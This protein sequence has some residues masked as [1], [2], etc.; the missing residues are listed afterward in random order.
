LGGASKLIKPHARASG[1]FEP[2]TKAAARPLFAPLQSVP[3]QLLS[4]EACEITQQIPFQVPD[5][6]R[7]GDVHLP[8]AKRGHSDKSAHQHLYQELAAKHSAD[9]STLTPPDDIITGCCLD[10]FH[11]NISGLSKSPIKSPISAHA[12][13][14]S[15]RRTEVPNTPAQHS[16]Q[17]NIP[18]SLIDPGGAMTEDD[19]VPGDGALHVE[20]TP[21]AKVTFGTVLCN[22]CHKQRLLARTGSTKTTC[23]KCQ[24][25]SLVG[26]PKKLEIPETP[27]SSAVTQNSQH[28]QQTSAVTRNSHLEQISAVVAQKSQSGQTTASM[29]QRSQPEKVATATTD[30]KSSKVTVPWFESGVVAAKPKIKKKIGQLAHVETLYDQDMI[31]EC[32]ASPCLE[33]TM[34][35]SKDADAISQ[36]YTTSLGTTR[37]SVSTKESQICVNES[38]QRECQNVGASDRLK[39]LSYGKRTKEEIHSGPPSTSSRSRGEASTPVSVSE[40]S[41]DNTVDSE[42]E[43]SL[44]KTS[45]LKEAQKFAGSATES[46]HESLTQG[47]RYGVRELARIALVSANGNHMTTSQVLIWIAQ[48]FPYLR[49]GEGGWERSVQACLSRFDEFDGRTIP[50]DRRNKKLYGFSGVE[51]R[52][53]YEKEYSEFLAASDSPTGTEGKAS[54]NNEINNEKPVNGMTAEE[55][56]PSQSFLIKKQARSNDQM[57]RHGSQIQGSP[58]NIEANSR[59]SLLSPKLRANH[60]ATEPPIS[61]ALPEEASNTIPL[62]PSARS[63]TSQPSGLSQPHQNI[64]RIITFQAAF[65]DSTPSI[66]TMTEAEKAQRIA[67]IKARPSRK[68]YFG[69]DYRLAHKRRYGLKDIHDEREG[70]WKRPRATMNELQPNMTGNVDPDTGEALTL[71]SLFGLPNNAIPMNDGHKELAFRDG[72]LVNGRLPRPRNVYKVG[73]LFGGELTIRMSCA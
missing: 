53:R 68:K 42:M 40:F 7:H 36:M 48:N 21:L 14:M 22:V 67:E 64:E 6:H 70:A 73:K 4:T 16:S 72:A 26:G 38:G 15:P 57:E 66:E 34:L 35:S 56:A 33:N 43:R 54:P 59:P 9:L 1:T 5:L 39:L 46:R 28:E 32:N 27:E 65:A 55:S 25:K 2:A 17:L 10:L 24:E 62:M 45:E 20:S 29:G 23:Q 50:G 18:S 69:E 71:R 3:V 30:L 41:T 49:M 58:A 52:K 63:A 47:R 60:T 44:P 37:Q 12:D 31:T 8:A 51:A 61:E 19:V 11:Q 13:T